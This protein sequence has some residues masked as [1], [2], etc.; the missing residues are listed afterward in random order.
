[1]IANV[2]K[3]APITAAKKGDA[4]GVVKEAGRPLILACKELWKAGGIRSLFAG[5]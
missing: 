1:M 3:G 2:D 5:M 4:A